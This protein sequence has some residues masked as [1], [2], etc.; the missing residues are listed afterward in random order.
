VPDLG[1]FDFLFSA[2]TTQDIFDIGVGKG[3]SVLSQIRPAWVKQ[4]FF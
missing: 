4:L 3:I 1:L 2:K